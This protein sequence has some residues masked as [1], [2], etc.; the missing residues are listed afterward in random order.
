MNPPYELTTDIF[1]LVT[2]ISEKLG[3]AKAL[4]LDK[5]SPQ[6]RKRN[7]IKKIHS[8]LK[9]EGNTLSEDQITAI[10]EN[11]RVI[12]SK[13]DILEVKN[14]IKVYG[15]LDQYDPKS[16]KSFLLAHKTLMNGL[17]EKAGQYRTEN[18]GVVQGDKV[19]HLAPPSSNVDYLMGELFKYLKTTNEL[20]LIKSCVFHYE[21]EFIH[22]FLDGN[23]R[24]GRLWQNLILLKE[25]SVFE[26]LPFETLI[27]DNQQAYYDALGKSDKAGN[28]TAFIEYML[29]IIDASLD[30]LL[31]FSNRPMKRSDRLMYFKSLRKESFSRKDYMEVFKEISTA[32]ASRDLQEGVNLGVF[33]KEGDKRNTIYKLVMDK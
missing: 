27:S 31:S 21:M 2:K 9:I 32:T 7:K 28:S 11:K 10:L 26:Y 8:S 29:T 4:H 14:A 6:L 5:P 22:P 23:G 18:V 15:S 24:M 16:A 19:A 30:D 33:K 1:R 12:G 20:T 13:Q 25:Y 3:E 17:I